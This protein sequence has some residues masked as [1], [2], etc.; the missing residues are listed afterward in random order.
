[1]SF[2]RRAW[3]AVACTAQSIWQKAIV[4]AAR[5]SWDRVIQPAF[6]IAAP[7]AVELLSAALLDML[8]RRLG[9]KDD[10]FAPAPN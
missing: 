5:W 7:I 8:R 9:P 6:E 2:F 4:P 3:Q 10:G 1:M